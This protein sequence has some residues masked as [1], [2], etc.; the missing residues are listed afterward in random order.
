[1]R[2]ACINQDRGIAPGRRKGASIHL[3]SMQ[4]AFR[5]LGAEVFVLHGT[6][7]QELVA[8]LDEAGPFDL[9]YERYAL[10]RSAGAKYAQ[11]HAL[12]HILEVN[13]PL[14][15]EER[16][17]RGRTVAG[18]RE[19]D[20]LVFASATR[21]IAV[22]SLVASYAVD[23]GAEAERVRVFHN[24][25]DANL[26][27]PRRN[28]GPLRSELAPA[29]SFILGF[30]GRLRPWHGFDQLVLAVRHLIDREVP[31]HLVVV[32]QGD[33]EDHLKGTVPAERVTLTGW[34]PHEEMPRYVST[35]DAL[36][37]TY[38]T[39]KPCYFSPLKLPEAMACGV[40]PVAPAVGDLPEVIVHEANG[41]LYPHGDVLALTDA[42]ER[43]FK[44][45]ALRAALADEAVRT[46][47]ETPWQASA[48]FALGLDASEVVSS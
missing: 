31:V 5:Q 40:V 29:G 39:S 23:R 24:G 2:V 28:G 13:S 10:G 36:P 47:R 45:P 44:E 30:H 21:V 9:V 27:Y 34:V 48:A 8:R 37:L 22:S 42:L 35:F 43:L 11:R 18:V 25:V 41:L 17:W 4:A 16:D 38:A 6:D 1:M 33:F 26:F 20:E 7:D 14:E 3:S 15:D 46:A 19:S 32:G 12:P